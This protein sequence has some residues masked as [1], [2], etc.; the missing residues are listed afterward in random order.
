MT[1]SH[2]KLSYDYSAA[3][4][5]LSATSIIFPLDD[6]IT[7]SPFVV[8]DVDGLG[9]PPASVFIAPTLN[10]G[11]VFQGRRPQ[12]REISMM[13]SFQPNY[14]AGQTTAD[15]RKELY[16]WATPKQA[17]PITIT[18]LDENFDTMM[19]TTGYLKTMEPNIFSKDPQVQMVFSCPSPYFNTANYAYPG[20]GA[21]SKNP[22]TLVNPGDAPSGFWM[23]LT[24]TANRSGFSLF[25]R[26]GTYF[27]LL[28]YSFLTNDII[29]ITTRPGFRSVTVTR[30]AVTTTLL[31]YQS[32]RSVWLQ[33]HGGTNVLLP[34]T[35]SL[36]LNN[37]VIYP[38]HWGI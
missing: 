35:Q 22:I 13:V 3:G 37:I 8:T 4:T 26:T 10:A 6:S 17:L 31:P 30:S 5:G 21:L 32:A 34:V 2:I 15:L 9:P 24:L 18:L 20:V 29:S 14:A 1:F 25:D 38:N 36:T 28:G 33:L 16:V 12:Y 19:Y 7:A 11:G 23:Q 27:E